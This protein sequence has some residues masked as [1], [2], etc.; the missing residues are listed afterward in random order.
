M[1]KILVLLPAFILAC[2]LVELLKDRAS[3]SVSS[4]RKIM[5]G[6]LARFVEII[7]IAVLASLLLKEVFGPPGVSLL[8]QGK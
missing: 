1:V 8:L 3:K 4:G 7:W 5:Y 2:C 6:A